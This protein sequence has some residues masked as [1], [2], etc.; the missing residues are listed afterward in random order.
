[1]LIL[2]KVGDIIIKLKFIIIFERR[3]MKMHG[4]MLSQYIKMLGRE[5]K[6]YNG[7][8]FL[9][10]VIAGITVGAVALPLA[11]AFG[12]ASVPNEYATIGI[13]AGLITAI[14]AGII[15]G[16]LGGA[17]FQI[18][19]PTGTMSV[20]LFGLIAGE[21]GF[22]GLFA[23]I[24]LAGVIRLLC[25]IFHLG[26]LIKYIPKPVVTGFTAGIALIIA[27]GQTGNFFGVSLAGATTVEKLT[28]FFANELSNISIPAVLASLGV[29]LLMVF[30]PKKI[31]KYIPGSLGALIVGTAV[32]AIFSIDVLVIK[33]NGEIPR[34]IM[35]SMH[36]NF[37]EINIP[38]L[39]D[40]AGPAF[41][42]AM[43]CMIETLLCG[44]CASKMKK[45]EFNPNIELV[46]QG[47]ANLVIP[48]FGGVPSTAAL[49]R[50][51]V[52]IRAGGQTRIAGVFHSLFLLACMFVLSSAIS[53]VPFC[54]LAGVL[55]VTAYRMNDWGQ[56]KCYFGGKM[57]GALAQ[58][59]TTMIVTVLVDLTY[60]VACGIVLA[61]VIYGINML[62]KGKN[63]S[64]LEIKKELSN[65]NATVQISGVCYFANSDKLLACN[66]GLDEAKTV[67]IDLGALEY[68]DY[69]VCETLA[70]VYENFKSNGASVNFK[71]VPAS[72]KNTLK[73][74][75]IEV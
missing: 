30:Y 26:K 40:V 42:I 69:T 12:A 75:G 73:L 10:D 38:M 14:L 17:G 7:K 44:T 62:K 64:S 45:E 15:T 49:A 41:S 54:A 28:Y 5:F 58:F 13:T 66:T 27:L 46:A 33:D 19:G 29:I 57:W 9:S 56:I 47:V 60:A 18:S 6:G 70:E 24:L 21:H 35:N 48:F 8:T 25:G 65:G 20:I 11:L 36:L 31:A 68:S 3:F 50:T 72:V 63:R 74:I 32:V 1:M 71:N 55:I 61:F 2:T 23:A 16:L 53:L 52:A 39:I 22:T 4:T 34:S 43:L 37:S 51:S 67:E 59:L